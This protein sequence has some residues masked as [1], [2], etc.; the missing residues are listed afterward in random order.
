MNI[1]NYARGLTAKTYSSICN[2]FWYVNNKINLF[3]V[4][5]H[6]FHI[7]K[8]RW[9]NPIWSTSIIFT[10]TFKHPLIFYVPIYL[11]NISVNRGIMTILSRN[12]GSNQTTAKLESLYSSYSFKVGHSNLLKLNYFIFS[13]QRFTGLNGWQKSWSQCNQSGLFPEA[14]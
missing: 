10:I 14:L 13:I 4:I 8:K 1:F 11:W 2:F 5:L 9:V 3:M 12:P 6:I 7:Y